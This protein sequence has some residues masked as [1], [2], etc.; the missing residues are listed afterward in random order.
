ME[1]RQ[2]SSKATSQEFPKRTISWPLFR[3]LLSCPGA[4]D[5]HTHAQSAFVSIAPRLKMLVSFS[6][7]AAQPSHVMGSAFLPSKCAQLPFGRCETVMHQCCASSQISYTLFLVWHCR[8]V[9]LAE[10]LVLHM[11]ALFRLKPDL[12]STAHNLLAALN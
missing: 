8:S 2:E 7:Y 4:P 9:L 12:P 5:R 6:I 1:W 10:Q 3:I 11:Y